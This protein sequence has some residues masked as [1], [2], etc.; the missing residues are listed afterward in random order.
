[1]GKYTYFYKIIIILIYKIKH[2]KVVN[3]ISACH[4]IYLCACR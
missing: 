4:G 3:F 1:M 2:E